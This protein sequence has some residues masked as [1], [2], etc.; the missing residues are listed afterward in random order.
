MRSTLH[1]VAGVTTSEIEWCKTSRTSADSKCQGFAEPI[2]RAIFRIW[3]VAFSLSTIDYQRPISVPDQSESVGLL[4]AALTSLSQETKRFTSRRPSRP[5]TVISSVTVISSGAAAV[6]QLWKPPSWL[7][8]AHSAENDDEPHLSPTS[9]RQRGSHVKFSSEAP[10]N[11][12]FNDNRTGLVYD[13]QLLPSPDPT[14][15]PQQRGNGSSIS[16]R[17]F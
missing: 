10:F 1:A 11:S 2:P 5:A 9:G 8:R 6:I 15:Y 17:S 13:S 7:E 3:E 14:D 12:K 4:Q 16:R